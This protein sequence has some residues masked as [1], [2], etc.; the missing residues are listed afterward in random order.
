MQAG[1]RITLV[2]AGAGAGIA[3]TFNQP[4]LRNLGPMR[5]GYN[6]AS[7][8]WRGSEREYG[9]GGGR[10]RRPGHGSSIMIACRGEILSMP[11]VRV[12]CLLSVRAAWLIVC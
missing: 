4:R 12:E 11:T 3:A 10:V 6:I 5:S 8:G 9:A 1:Q 2:A 7:S